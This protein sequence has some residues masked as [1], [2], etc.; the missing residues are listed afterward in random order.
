MA[1][2]FLSFHTNKSMSMIMSANM[3]VMTFS[4]PFQTGSIT[5]KVLPKIETKGLTAD[6]V[7]TLS[8]QSFGIMRSAYMKISGQTV[9]S[10]GPSTHWASCS[11]HALSFAPTTRM[12]WD[13]VIIVMVVMLTMTARRFSILSD[14]LMKQEHMS[15]QT[16]K[17]THSPWLQY[18]QQMSS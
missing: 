7:T 14:V 11:C 17:H 3:T 16:D 6:D 13:Y 4:A 10:N 15:I 12:A 1:I 9:Q 18:I 2:I 5:L 8:E